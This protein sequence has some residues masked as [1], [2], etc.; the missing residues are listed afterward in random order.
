MSDPSIC[1]KMLIRNHNF[2]ENIL[3][4]SNAIDY[5]IPNL[6]FHFQPPEQTFQPQVIDWTW[7]G[8]NVYTSKEKCI[9]D[10]WG[11]AYE[12][13]SLMCVRGGG[14]PSVRDPL[15]GSG[16][17]VGYLQTTLTLWRTFRSTYP[18]GE[19][20]CMVQIIPYLTIIRPPHIYVGIALVVFFG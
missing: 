1:W 20:L 7:L 10:K 4:K 15:M 3:K 17:V 19:A 12:N 16:N 14:N 6:I 8:E 2:I 18:L 5:V 9:L 13:Y 11:H